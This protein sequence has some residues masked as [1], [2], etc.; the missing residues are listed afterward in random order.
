M[1]FPQSAE[2]IVKVYRTDTGCHFSNVTVRLRLFS[3]DFRCKHAIR[4]ATEPAQPPPP[5]DQLS[6][7]SCTVSEK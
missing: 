5:A 6:P 7:V 1:Q 4:S 2:F 3:S